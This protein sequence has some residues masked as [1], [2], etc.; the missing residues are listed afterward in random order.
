MQKFV[1]GN[2][3]GELGTGKEYP[4][5]FDRR[6]TEKFVLCVGFHQQCLLES[7]VSG[8]LFFYFALNRS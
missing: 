1:I 6:L 8:R 4:E 7:Y 2:D 5:M 3:V